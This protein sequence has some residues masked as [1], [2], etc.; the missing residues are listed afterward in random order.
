[1]GENGGGEFNN[2]PQG[3]GGLVVRL[4][5]RLGLG[6]REGGGGSRGGKRKKFLRSLRPWP[7]KRGKAGEVGS[8]VRG[9]LPPCQGWAVL[10][11]VSRADALRFI[12]PPRWGGQGDGWRLGLRLG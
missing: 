1:M 2:L 7:T 10:L 9:I 8:A 4:R 5:L 3:V 12:F 11:A 6:G